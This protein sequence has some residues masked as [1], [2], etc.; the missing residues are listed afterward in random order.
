M[1]DIIKVFYEVGE[2]YKEKLVENYNESK[3]KNIEKE[4]IYIL[5]NDPIS[6]FNI[7]IELNKKYHVKQLSKIDQLFL[8]E[9][10]KKN[11]K[12]IIDISKLKNEDTQEI[13]TFS[14]ESEEV[15]SKL[16]DDD[17]IETKTTSTYQIHKKYICL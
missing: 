2:A 13:E 1:A 7:I 6:F 11:P 17:V 16:F 5:N 3:S 10:E 9:K 12:I 15:T 4:K 14:F 8:V